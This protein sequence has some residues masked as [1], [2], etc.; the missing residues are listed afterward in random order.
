MELAQYIYMK[1]YKYFK[2]IQLEMTNFDNC[3]KIP[4]DFTIST[5]FR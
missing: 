3:K 5:P 2:I 4:K 1:M